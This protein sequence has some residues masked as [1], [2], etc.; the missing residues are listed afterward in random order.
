[1]WGLF[2]RRA[3]GEG[4]MDKHCVK[5]NKKLGM[6]D[7]L[8]SL[9]TFKLQICISCQKDLQDYINKWLD[10]KKKGGEVH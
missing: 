3:G 9:M 2:T 6:P 1:M 5:C 8:S 10:T 4:V 7:L